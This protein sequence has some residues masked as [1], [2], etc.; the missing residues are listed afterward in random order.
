AL[1]DSGSRVFI[2]DFGTGYSSLSYLVSLPFH[3]LKIDRSFVVGML[4]SASQRSIIA[5]VISM[6][7]TLNLRAVA[8]GVETS[9]EL[10]EL[11]AMGC[12]EVQGYVFDAPMSADRLLEWTAGYVPK[13]L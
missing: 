5:S 9:Q 11:Q 8:E 6:A 10:Q 2:D 1:R 13:G 4:R 7:H 12:D 3:A